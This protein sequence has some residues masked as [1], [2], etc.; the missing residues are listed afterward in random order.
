MKGIMRHLRRVEKKA[1]PKQYR[2][3]QHIRKM[4]ELTEYCEGTPKVKT[5]AEGYCIVT[6]DEIVDLASLQPMTL[7]EIGELLRF[8]KAH[9]KGRTASLDAREK[10]SFILIKYGQ[11]RGLLT[12]L[13]EVKWEW[14]GETFYELEVQF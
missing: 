8:F 4:S 11:K 14:D 6:E 13:K 10:T 1:Y 2:Q 7:R 12:V 9:F 3:M 5:W